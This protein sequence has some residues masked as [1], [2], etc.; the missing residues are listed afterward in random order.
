MISSDNKNHSNSSRPSSSFRSNLQSDS[1]AFT[2]AS[3]KEAAA[4]QKAERSGSLRPSE[5]S[6]LTA[7]DRLAR[8][9]EIARE[10]GV[11]PRR[12]TA[13]TMS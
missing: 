13:R 4:V 7:V 12:R 5:R 3:L 8:A 6:L 10:E 2:A 9:D 11:G 1:N